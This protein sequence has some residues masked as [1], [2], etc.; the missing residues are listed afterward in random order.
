M[1]GNVGNLTDGGEQAYLCVSSS[2]VSGA[3]YVSGA[4]CL[5]SVMATQGEHGRLVGP[6]LRLSRGR[7]EEGRFFVAQLSC[8]SV[9]SS[10]VTLV[11]F[12]LYYWCADPTNAAATAASPG[13]SAASTAA[14]TPAA[15]A[16]ASSATAAATTT[17]GDATAAGD[18]ARR[19]E[20][21]AEVSTIY[22]GCPSSQFSNA[23][24]S[25]R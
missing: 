24:Y 20:P 3:S 9:L 18:G 5:E 7:Q 2:I 16:P 23:R 22:D 11:T 13:A 6:W 4:Y 14:S 17:A 21:R 19:P 12:S 15:P 8:V 25:H 1:V 10:R